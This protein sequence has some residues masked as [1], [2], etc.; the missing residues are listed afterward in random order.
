MCVA[1]LSPYVEGANVTVVNQQ[2]SISSLYGAEEGLL[3]LGSRCVLLVVL[4]KER[5]SAVTSAS[6]QCTLVHYKAFKISLKF[7]VRACTI[8]YIGWTFTKLGLCSYRDSTV[9]VRQNSEYSF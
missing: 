2:M 3:L 7:R 9:T 4:S 5:G 6:W 1:R 8:P